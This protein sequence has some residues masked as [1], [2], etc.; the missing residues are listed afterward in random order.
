MLFA[1]QGT[2]PTIAGD[3]GVQVIA[4]QV[5]ASGCYP[6]ALQNMYPLTIQG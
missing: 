5:G 2:L 1:L 3:G 4:S 6:L